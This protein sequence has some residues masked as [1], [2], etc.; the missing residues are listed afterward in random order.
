MVREVVQLHNHSEYSI[1]DGRTRIAELV[2]AAKGMG[3]AAVALTDHGNLHGMMEFYRKARS[4]GIK[5]ILGVELYVTEGPMGRKDA[6]LDKAGSSFHLTVL[7][8]DEIGYANVLKLVSR[9][10]MDGFYYKPRVD[11]ACLEQHAAGLVVLSGCLGSQV[12]Q[13]V[14]NGDFSG[15]ESIIGQY[16][17]V[18]GAENYFLEVHNHG[19]EEQKRVNGW[20][21]EA[22]KRF[23][24]HVVAACDSH[25]ARAADAR[26]HDILLAIQT[27][28]Q[29]DDPK[30]FRIEPY[31]QYYLKSADEMYEAFSGAEWV[32]ANTVGVAE[33]CT[34]ELDHS[35]V[36]L[37]EFEIPGGL[38][39]EAWLQ[40]KVAAGLKARFG[41][42]SDEVI[43]RAKMELRVINETGYAR[44]FLI[45]EDYVRHAR[46]NGVMAVPRG[47]V[48]GSLCMYALGIC[49]IDPVRY[50]IMFERFLHAERKGMP[51]VDMDFAD[52]RRD[53]VIAYVRNKYGTERVAHIGTFQTLGARASV[54][55][56]AR[57]LGMDYSE[58]NRLTRSLPPGL[59]LAEAMETQEM[60]K[61]VEDGYGEVLGLAMEL[62]GL[63]R[64][65]GTHAAGMLIAATELVD[66][67]PIQLP[68]GGKGKTAVTQWDNNNTSQVIESIGL[69]KFDF[70]GLAN[71]TVIREACRMIRER[72]G[73]DLYGQ[74]GEKLYA[75]LPVDFLEPMARR[76][77]DLLAAGET[78]AVFQLE[79]PGMRRA[80]R[81]VK[82]TRIT[83]LPAIVALYRPGPMENIPVFAQAKSNPDMVPFY[84]DDV[85][86]LLAETYGIVTYQDQVLLIARKLAGF[87]W[88]EVDVLRKGMGKKQASVIDEQRSKFL[89]G[90]VARGYEEEIAQ[91]IWETMAPFAGYGFNKA[92]AYCYGYVAYI[93]AFLKANFTIEYL[94]AVLTQEAGNKE[95]TIEAV[96]ECKRMGVEVSVPDIHASMAE[97]SIDG[98]RIL[99]GLSSVGGLGGAGVREILGKRP[100]KDYR[101]FLKTTSVSA[102]G[103][104]GL[105][106]SGAMERWGDGNLLLAI[107]PDEN[108]EQTVWDQI[109]LFPGEYRR[110]P[111][112]PPVTKEQRLEWEKEILGVYVSG[113][114]LDA[115]A[116]VLSR[117]TRTTDVQDGERSLVGGM[118][119]KKRMHVQKNGKSMVFFDIE[120]MYGAL[121]CV[122]FS[123]SYAK[124]AD[125]IED[126]TLMVA[127]G[128]VRFRD[129]MPSFIVEQVRPI[130]GGKS[131]IPKPS[132]QRTPAR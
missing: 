26:S 30:R 79:S 35:K 128:E 86:P 33:M 103:V 66:V 64:G 88:G 83:D 102:R 100:F 78:T 96:A 8:K 109:E 39:S 91:E 49:D 24:L 46:E 123:H 74:S 93:T 92:H 59:T 38:T 32:V 51:D 9:A 124:H 94:C 16:R 21:L 81:M 7:A 43:D 40:R 116:S 68:P 76:A 58:T 62:E 90:C 34:V 108:R 63:V 41:Q 3:Q 73:V 44:Y 101:H 52:D 56:V 119:S 47:S 98:E 17:D 84:H 23:G 131:E 75:D 67:V 2:G 126:G 1:L 77:Y 115:V 45:V 69:S 118:L 87:S 14:K 105:V 55:D 42:P 6:Q 72:H 13:R 27:G 53:D 113:H 54:K 20:L 15:A 99:L 121:P 37:P 122:M 22:G 117:L 104:T 82:P 71:L 106:K 95:K 10:H 114:P 5:P 11:F 127:H 110:I 85:T 4:E 28:S 125:L 25:Y 29:M 36:Q 89:A 57:V 19:M 97:C 60:R 130:G 120:D 61:A 12:S 129:E 50:D 48:A 18:F 111:Q 107:L 70:L 31:G 65:F 80:L 112:T 132:L